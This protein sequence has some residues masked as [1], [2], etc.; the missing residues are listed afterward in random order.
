M[1]FELKRKNAISLVS[2]FPAIG[3]RLHRGDLHATARW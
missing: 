1:L 2:I 3:R